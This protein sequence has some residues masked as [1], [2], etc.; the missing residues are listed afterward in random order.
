MKMQ[1]KIY[2][3]VKMKK[4]KY[5]WLKRL[6]NNPDRVASVG[7]DVVENCNDKVIAHRKKWG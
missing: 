5:K 7:D 3:C 2:N 6:Q 1:P 4:C